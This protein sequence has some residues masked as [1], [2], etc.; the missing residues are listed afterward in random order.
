MQ[1]LIEATSFVQYLKWWSDERDERVVTTRG[2]RVSPPRVKV[3]HSS[4]SSLVDDK[5]LPPTVYIYYTLLSTSFSNLTLPFRYLAYN[6]R[7]RNGDLILQ[8]DQTQVRR[9]SIESTCHTFL[10]WTPNAWYVFIL[11]LMR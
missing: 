1:T 5:V 8:I 6:L 9:E 4:S 2:F 7:K 3:I 10:L 11:C